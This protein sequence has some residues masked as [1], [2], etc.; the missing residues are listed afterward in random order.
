MEIGESSFSYFPTWHWQVLFDRNSLA[1][2]K[3]TTKIKNVPSYNIRYDGIQS[4]LSSSK[5]STAR[6]NAATK[7]HC[8]CSPLSFSYAFCMSVLNCSFRSKLPF[9]SSAFFSNSTR[10]YIFGSFDCLCV[11]PTLRHFN[12]NIEG[13]AI[14]LRCFNRF[15]QLIIE[16]SLILLFSFSIIYYQFDAGGIQLFSTVCSYSMEFIIF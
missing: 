16:H 13:Y 2:T 6:N 8:R 1:E 14:F 10:K 5:C 11:L 9:N 15:D 3:W 4:G 7:Q 12:V